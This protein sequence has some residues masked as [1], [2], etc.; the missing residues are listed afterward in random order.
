M[1]II[2]LSVH[3]ETRGKQR[4]TPK[5]CLKRTC[6][7]IEKYHW[8]T[9]IRFRDTRTDVYFKS[10][11]SIPSLR[12]SC[13]D[14]WGS[15]DV[16]LWWRWS[17]RHC[18]NSLL[19]VHGARWRLI[20]MASFNDKSSFSN[21]PTHPFIKNFQQWSTQSA[22]SKPN[23][24]TGIFL[25]YLRWSKWNLTFWLDL[26]STPTTQFHSTSVFELFRYEIEN[27]LYT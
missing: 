20:V 14:F 1:I 11:T 26:T 23:P 5:T 12:V 8:F 21:Y 9:L 15:A 19:P 27:E 4:H 22:S 25:W 16:E 7:R 17:S 13:L 3:S 6:W 10:D 18:V 2:M 24:S